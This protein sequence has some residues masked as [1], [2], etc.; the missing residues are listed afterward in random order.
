MIIPIVVIIAIIVLYVFFFFNGLKTTE[1]HI[2]AAIQE[3]GNQ[4]KRQ[5]QLIPNLIESVKGYMSHEKGIFEDLTAAR[6]LIDKAIDTKDPKAID[7]A[8]SLLNKTM[9]SIKVIAESN[10]EI[11]ASNLVGNMME[12]LRDT[13]DKIMYARRTFIDLSADFNI[14]ISTIPGM[15]LAPLFGFTKK[16]GLETT[17]AKNI[18]TV[19]EDETKNP[20]VKLN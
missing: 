6:K 8:Q 3:I 2:G 16:P 20:E 4:L 5:S 19:S 1:V 15:W 14:K 13:A 10:P 11:K 7:A 18:T 12:E 17:D 9:G